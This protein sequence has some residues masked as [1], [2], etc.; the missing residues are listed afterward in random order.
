MLQAMAHPFFDELRMP[1]AGA[2]LVLPDLFSFSADEM[3][4]NPAAYQD[5]IPPHRRGV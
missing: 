5:L 3:Q 1:G 2:P 4:S